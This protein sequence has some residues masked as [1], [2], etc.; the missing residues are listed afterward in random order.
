LTVVGFE[1][2][3]GAVVQDRV[4]ITLVDELRW[5]E[6]A[7][8]RWEIT[9]DKSAHAAKRDRIALIFVPKVGSPKRIG[10]EMICKPQTET[11][12]TALEQKQPQIRQ[13]ES[14]FTGSDPTAFFVCVLIIFAVVFVAAGL[15]LSQ[16]PLSWLGNGGM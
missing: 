13:L 10:L 11:L 15:L 8:W 1:A 5:H 7:G 4:N 3:G 16:G 12:Q 2:Q 14:H 6:I 9:R